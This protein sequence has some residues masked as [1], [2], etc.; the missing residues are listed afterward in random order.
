MP[1]GVCE[2]VCVLCISVHAS[3]DKGVDRQWALGKGEG[4]DVS[5]TWKSLCGRVGG[6]DPDQADLGPL[7]NCALKRPRAIQVPICKMGLT[8][9]A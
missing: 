8:A 9:V 4:A 3:G 1:V 5:C 7:A 2:C 6:G